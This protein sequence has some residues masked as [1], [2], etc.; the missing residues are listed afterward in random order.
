MERLVAIGGGEIKDLET[1]IIDREIV[2]LTDKAHPHA[3]F[4]PTASGDPDGYC[5]TFHQVYGDKLGCRTDVLRVAS[6]TPTNQEIED[7]ISWAD[8]VYVGGGNT[9][10]M[11][12]RWRQLGVDKLLKKAY[13]QG[14]VMS[15]LSAGSICWFEYGH[16]DSNK[17]KANQGDQWNFM[18]VR[19]LGFIL[20]THCPH[21]HHEKRE[22]GFDEMIRRY[23]GTGIALDNNTALE[24]MDSKYRIIT[25]ISAPAAYKLYKSS[26]Q[27]VRVPLP[28]T[29]EFLPLSDL[30]Q[31][32]P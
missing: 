15:D 31:R 23:G 21:Y 27:V 14:T 3:L 28:A 24:V 4:I 6:R 11:L 12:R 30:F 26:N 1:L 2:R 17:F 32:Q 22:I 13:Q 29:T 19:G 20:G 16:S 8:L 9:L 5:Q 25:A 10:R 18:R 7:K